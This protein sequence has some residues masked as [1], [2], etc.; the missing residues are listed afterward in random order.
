MS[1]LATVT[2][3]LQSI[4]RRARLASVAQEPLELTLSPEE[5]ATLADA[6]TA[7]LEDDQS[8]YWSEE[9]Q[10]GERAAEAD[11]AAGRGQVFDTMEDFL[12]DLGLDLDEVN[13][14]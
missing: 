5:S 7:A 1:A 8:W 11:L 12:Q 6:L 14:A 4:A 10:A 3:T 2:T 9:W 13:R